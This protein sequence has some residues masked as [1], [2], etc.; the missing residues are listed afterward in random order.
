MNR[1]VNRKTIE[2]HAF[3]HEG[4]ELHVTVT[5]GVARYK[6]SDDIRQWIGEAEQRMYLGKQQGKNR[7]IMTA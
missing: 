4:K 5:I 3:L 1:L 6:P 7:V 2:N